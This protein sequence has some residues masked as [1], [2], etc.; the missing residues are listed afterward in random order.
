MDYAIKP[1]T[2]ADLDAA[3]ALE[4]AAHP[5]PWPASIFQESLNNHYQRY[6]LW[7]EQ[8]LIGMA[9]FAVVAPEAELLN[10]AIDP[11]FQGQGA[12]QFFLH[13][14][15]KILQAQAQERCF[16]E[17]RASNVAAIKLYERLKFNQIGV[18]PGYYPAKRGR[19]D[20]YLYALELAYLA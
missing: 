4:V 20:A 5:F 12:G 2:H 13:A 6:A 11:S 10:I 14:L 17:V 3:Y 18:R 19:E 8:R 9:F 7:Q 15:L 16:L 1:L